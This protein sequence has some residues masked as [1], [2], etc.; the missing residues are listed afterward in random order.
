MPLSL[1]LSTR[2]V[3]ERCIG[4]NRAY[5]LLRCPAN[6]GCKA[7]MEV[8]LAIVML[9]VLF[10]LSADAKVRKPD[11]PEIGIIRVECR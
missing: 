3:D 7:E 4:Y 10:A 2:C 6:S 8:R 5:A 1:G 11:A 9:I